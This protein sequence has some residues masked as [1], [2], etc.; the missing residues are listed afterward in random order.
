M[1][2][3][4][5]PH[6]VPETDQKCA[7]GRD[8]TKIGEDVTE[9]LDYVPGKIIVLRHIYPKYACSCCQ[10]GV[11]AAA[12]PPAPV[13]AAW[14][15]LASWRMSSSASSPT[16]LPLYRQQDDLARAGVFLWRST[17]CGWIG[18]CAQLLK[19]LVELMHP[20]SEV[21]G[22]PKPTRPPYP[23]WIPPGFDADGILLGHVG[24]RDHPYTVYL[25]TDSRSQEGPSE[26]LKDFGGFLQTDAYSAYESVISKSEGRIIPVGCWAI[27]GGTS[28]TPG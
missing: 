4:D 19:P 6:D 20:S 13:T 27:D 23:C 8:K 28:S 17:L 18:Q 9:Q 5:V 7:C 14:P 26:F 11:T 10:D 22:H 12:V 1:P 25:Y 3:Q 21:G 15:R 2:R 24:D 16:H